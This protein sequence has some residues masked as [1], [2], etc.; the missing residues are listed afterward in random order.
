M[1]A[2]VSASGQPAANRTFALRAESAFARAQKQFA[3]HPGE[4]AAAWQLGRASYDWAEFATNS[5]QRAAVAQAG[6]AAC[7]HLLARDPKS[8]AGHYYLAM[9]F[10]QLAEAEAPSIAA[11]KLVKEIE[12]EFKTAAELDEKLDFAG[13]P[14]CL[15]LLYR[16]APSWPVSIGSKHKAREWL[17]RAAALAPDFP[18]NQLNLAESQVRWRQ[19][20]EAEKA[21][22]KLEALW[23]A[24]RTN[25][26]GEIW[27]PSWDDW[28]ARRAA[29]K[30]DFQKAFKRAPE[31]PSF[32]DVQK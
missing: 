9:D 5:E 2:A 32:S 15:G 24:A 18:E 16:D 4:P 25:L 19:A 14:R 22:K 12:H 27:E 30:A 28:T 6:I 8:A 29:V 3:E 23:P 20:G 10:G 31:V 1:L 11:Y 7:R 26:T 17:D 21:F 13:P